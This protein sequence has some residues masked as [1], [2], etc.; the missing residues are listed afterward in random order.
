MVEVAGVLVLVV[1]FF[2]R[3]SEK[4]GR[5]A[6][7]VSSSSPFLPLIPPCI[8]AHQLKPLPRLTGSAQS[9]MNMRI[10]VN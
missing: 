3:R 5:K 10:N 4:D 1:G 7:G 2:L 6:K 8:L 9:G